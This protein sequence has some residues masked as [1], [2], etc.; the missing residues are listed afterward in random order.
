MNAGRCS[1]DRANRVLDSVTFVAVTSLLC[2]SSTKYY[3]AMFLKKTHDYMKKYKI[4]IQILI[5]N[6]MPAK[7][8]C[9]L[10]RKWPS[11]QCFGS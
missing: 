5:D 11:S 10:T 7:Q 2:T 1:A 8:L 9:Y 3:S 4:G 6:V